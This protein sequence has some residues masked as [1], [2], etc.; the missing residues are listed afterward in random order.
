MT[1]VPNQQPTL[2]KDDL[3]IWMK[4]SMRGNDYGALITLIFSALIAWY[5]VVGPDLPSN[6]ATENEVFRAA[7]YAD[8][9]RE[10]NLYP[11]WDAHANTGYGAPIPHYT[12][13]GAPYLSALIE[14][15]M[16]Q[17]TIAA[18][19]IVYAMAFLLGGVGVYGI[20]V[21]HQ[22]AGAGVLAALLY[23]ASPYLST[24][25]PHILGDLSGTLALGLLPVLLWSVHRLLSGNYPHDY[26]FV[27]LTLSMLVLTHFRMALVGGIML[28]LLAAWMWFR[29]DCQ[30]PERLVASL[31]TSALLTSF[32]WLPF[33]T[34]RGDVIWQD[35]TAVNYP[36]FLTWDRFLLPFRQIDPGALIASPPLMLGWLHLGII[37]ISIISVVRHRRW[38]S[39]EA[40]FLIIGAVLTVLALTIFPTEVWLLGII[41]MCAAIGSSAGLQLRESLPETIQRLILVLAL[42]LVLGVS[43]PAW[44]PPAPVSIINDTSPASQVIYEERGYGIASMPWGGRNPIPITSQQTIPSPTLT[45]GYAQ[46]NLTRYSHSNLASGLSVATLQEQSHRSTYQIRS[47]QDSTLLVLR[48][49]F[50]GWRASTSSGPVRLYPG[51]DG[52]IRVDIPAIRGQPETL[53]IW[54]GTTPMRRLGWLISLVG[55]VVLTGLT[56]RAYQN[57]EEQYHEIELLTPAETRLIAMVL[58]FAA[59]IILFTASPN[60][61]FSARS[62]PGVGLVDTTPI[63]SRTTIGLNLL[64]YDINRST[65]QRGDNIELTLYWSTL[66]PLT[67]NYYTQIT[68]SDGENQVSKA[69]LRYPGGYPTTRWPTN[70]YVADLHYIN[71]PDVLSPGTYQ[72][73]VSLENCAPTDAKCTN[74][75]RPVFFGNNG[76]LLGDTL[77]LPVELE[78]Q[79]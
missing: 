55:V 53:T 69:V 35:F 47:E 70:R 3:P 49:Y 62:S 2:T 61:R 77:A 50:P 75:N 4:R 30:H 78:I 17:N 72:L 22:G 59:L 40:L 9:L 58:V 44:L 76:N 33:V 25:S 51:D 43:A 45:N 54:L 11:R 57:T 71:I 7:N 68:L 36:L 41:A 10:G 67:S 48:S 37:A 39:L 79:P 24:T 63:E 19:R 64:S 65:F 6:T 52:L 31:S 13:P 34:E 42:L 26:A 14:V 5:F 16:T 1:T 23:V 74:Q 32:F 12:P 66:L 21:R 46:G 28:V 73:L 8:T 56:Y 29:K 18:V 27:S 60:A 15:T 38:R 20:V